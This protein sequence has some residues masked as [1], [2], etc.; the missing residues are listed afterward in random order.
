M[1]AR[2][3]IVTSIRRYLAADSD[4]PLYTDTILNPIVQEA[5]DSLVTDINIQNRAYNSTTVTLTADS[6][7]SHLYTFATQSSPLTDFSGWLEM[8]LIDANGL[9]MHEVPMD[10]LREAGEG[11]F[12][13]TG[14][15][16]AGVLESSLDTSAGTAVW[17]RYTQWPALLSGDSS[18]PGGIPL[19]FHDVI[20]LEAL[21][22]FELGGE[23]RTP[24]RLYTRWLDR[25]AQLIHHVGKR[26]AQ[27]SRTRLYADTGALSI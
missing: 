10:G 20:A 9:A 6:T 5:A 11:H 21:Y 24:Q 26:G 19:R 22:A 16:S 27:P 7:T 17:M 13:I 3:T 23:S 14:I 25:R 12:A 1:A 4:D 15:D 18:V 2:S 8:R